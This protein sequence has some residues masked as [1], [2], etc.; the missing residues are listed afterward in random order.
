[1]AV[2]EG[3][4][5]VPVKR[6]ILKKLSRDK[7]PLE[8][9]G[10]YLDQNSLIVVRQAVLKGQSN[11]PKKEALSKASHYLLTELKGETSR[12]LISGSAACGVSPSL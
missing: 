12:G 4:S 7:Q 1:L 10:G 3:D 6:E 5:S 11:S 8:K 9:G 2:L